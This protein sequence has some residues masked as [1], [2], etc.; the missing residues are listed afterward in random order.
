MRFR[1]PIV[2]AWV[3]TATAGV[4]EAQTPSV[5][6]DPADLGVSFQRCTT[7]DTL[8]RTITFYLSKPPAGVPDAGLPVALWVQGSGCQSL[9]SKRGDAVADGLQG[10]LLKEAN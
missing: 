7:T 5:A 9:F 10:V 2:F 1:F 6:L 3:V 4:V 8:G